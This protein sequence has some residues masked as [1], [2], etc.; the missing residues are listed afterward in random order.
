[1]FVLLF[2]LTFGCELFGTEVSV[3]RSSLSFSRASYSLF[4]YMRLF[5][6]SLIIIK[7]ETL[8]NTLRESAITICHCFQRFW[9]KYY[10]RRDQN[11]GSYIVQEIRC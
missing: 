11:V 3:R 6:Y 2:F 7:P 9:I 5:L 4:Y 1:M 10:K 8:P